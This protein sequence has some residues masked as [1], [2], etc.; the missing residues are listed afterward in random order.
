[1]RFKNIMDFF[2]PKQ[3]A[4]ILLFAACIGGIGFLIH[5]IVLA[6][7]D[8]FDE[9]VFDFLASFSPHWEIP[10]FKFI[11]F[12]GSTYFLLP[13]YCIVI[14]LLFYKNH[15]ADAFDTALLGISSTLAVY[16][17]KALFARNRPKLPV[18]SELKN[19]SF[20]SGHA[21]SSFVFFA[22]L[23]WIIWKSTIASKWKWVLTGI[24]LLFVLAVGASRIVLRYHY[25]SD[26]LAGLI[27]GLVY[28]I[29]F[30]YL[31]QYIRK[32]VD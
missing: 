4:A 26:V 29:L 7:Q 8:K 31:R 19:Y 23:A 16:G 13:A 22:I 1:M 32:S 11:T 27:L 24:C 14:V 15:N 2:G 30:F 3:L 21:L 28:V 5:E 18:L 17:L 9:A 10:V 25:S 6:N 12:F 20:P